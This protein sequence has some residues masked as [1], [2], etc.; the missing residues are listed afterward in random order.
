MIVYGFNLTKASVVAKATV[1]SFGPI[2]VGKRARRAAI[3]EADAS[4]A[5][6]TST[7]AGLIAESAIALSK[8]IKEASAPE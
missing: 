8:A 4:V 6:V 1:E 3:C 7:E 2:D 5:L